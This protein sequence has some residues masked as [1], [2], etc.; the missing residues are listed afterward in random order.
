MTLEFM[1]EPEL[2]VDHVPFLG[3]AALYR[4]RGAP[5]ELRR[6]S[7]GT[8]S[9]RGLGV[10]EAGVVLFTSDGPGAMTKLLN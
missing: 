8:F 10:T 7:D 2:Q 5:L 6:A 1:I 3:R 4:F 9:S